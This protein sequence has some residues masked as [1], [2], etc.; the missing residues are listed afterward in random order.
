MELVRSVCWNVDRFS[1]AHSTL[2]PSESSLQFTVKKNKGLLEIMA[3]RWRTASR[4][5]V[6]IDKSVS[7]CSIHSGQQ[8]RVG[9]ADHGEMRQ[10]RVVGPDHGYV[11]VRIVG[12]DRLEFRCGV[13]G[14]NRIAPTRLRGS[15]SVADAEFFVRFST[16]P[17]IGRPAMV[18]SG[19]FRPL[20]EGCVSQQ[21]PAGGSPRRPRRDAE[22]NRERVLAAAVFAMMRDGRHVPLATIAAEAGVGVGTLYRRYPDREA[23]LHALEYRAYGLLNQILG[24]IDGQ[25]LSGLRAIEEFLAGSLAIGDQ[26]VLPLHGAPPLMSAEAVAA[27][28]E[29]NRRLDRFIARGRADG[30][31]QAPVNATD[32]IIFSAIVTQ[33]PAYGPDWQLLARRQLAIFVNGMA[34]HGPVSIPGPPV[35]RQDIEATFAQRAPAA[36]GEES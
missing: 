10:A 5:N 33:P 23:L 22:L 13:V 19:I 8:D 30:S 15:R 26:L 1:S 12:G 2:L 24:D 36:P 18:L 31:I 16:V 29:I 21:S 27:R 20:R 34:G 32:V 9:V 28:R 25:P 11:P 6:H 3:M 7:T 14:A 4:R 35:T 17:G